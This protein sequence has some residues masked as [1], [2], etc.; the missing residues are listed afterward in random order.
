M[1]MPTPDTLA[2]MKAV[3][4]PKG[5]IDTPD[6][7][8]AYLVERR[9]LYQGRAAAVLRPA[10]TAEVSALMKI[11]YETNTKVVPQGGNT[12]LVGG[13]IPF[14]AG[15]VILSLAR[16]T[17]VGEVDGLNNTL[18]VEDGVRSGEQTS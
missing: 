9:D 16:M 11:A 7:M 17:N 15:H 14:E 5:F 2:R 13:Q 1:T 3:V 4:G 18:T 10:S 6:D 8:A 12:G